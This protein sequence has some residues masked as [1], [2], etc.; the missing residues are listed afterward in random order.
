MIRMATASDEES[1]LAMARDF[2]AFSPYA[3]LA[4]AT[5]Q[6]LRATIQWLTNNAT[7]FIAD[8]DNRPVGL[9]VAVISPLWYAPSCKVASE[10]AWWIDP[11]H[12]TGMAATRLV[13]AF[14]KWAKDNGAKAVCMSNLDVENAT[15]VSRM[16]NKLG[17][18]STEQTHTKRI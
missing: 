10:M 18:T 11:Q 8:K 1:L 17:Y 7:I 6:E 15:A 16:L 4:T 12:R 2:V 14:E 5:D 3:D 13:Q 9:L